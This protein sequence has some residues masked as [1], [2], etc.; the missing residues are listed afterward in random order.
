MEPGPKEKQQRLLAQQ[1]RERM[2]ARAAKATPTPMGEETSP[3]IHKDRSST[4][5]KAKRRNVGR[6]SRPKKAA[7]KKRGKK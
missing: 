7:K 3:A 4:A 5:A 1:K 6:G 2:Q